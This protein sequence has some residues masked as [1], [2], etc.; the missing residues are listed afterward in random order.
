[1]TWLFVISYSV[2]EM[3]LI[4][5]PFQPLLWKPVLFPQEIQLPREATFKFH[6]K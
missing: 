3:G 5:I 1:M 4:Y 6:Y 2:I